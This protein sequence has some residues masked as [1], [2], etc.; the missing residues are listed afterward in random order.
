MAIKV[1]ETDRISLTR[2]LQKL[3]DE[4]MG[5]L[6]EDLMAGKITKITEEK[7]IK[8]MKMYLQATGQC[9]VQSGNYYDFHKKN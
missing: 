2:Q 1:K 8:V 7:Q 9:T 3:G 6:A 5:D 4:K